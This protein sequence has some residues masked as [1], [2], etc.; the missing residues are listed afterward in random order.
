MKTGSVLQVLIQTTSALQGAT[1]LPFMMPRNE[2]PSHSLQHLLGAFHLPE[3]RSR[4]FKIAI[5]IHF[6]N[7]LAILD[8]VV[9][10]L[11][12]I[13]PLGLLTIFIRQGVL[14]KHRACIFFWQKHDSLKLPFTISHANDHSVFNEKHFNRFYVEKLLHQWKNLKEPI[15]PNPSLWLNIIFTVRQAEPSPRQTPHW[16]SVALEFIS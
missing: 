3:I 15:L 16:S 12:W 8:F 1:L 5:Y 10:S 4:F 6:V 2:S 9:N 11:T 7:A 13:G 14:K